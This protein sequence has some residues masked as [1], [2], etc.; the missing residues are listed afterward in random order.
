[1][2]KTTERPILGTRFDDGLHLAHE[3]HRTQVRKGKTTPYVAHLL[4]VCSLVLEDGGDE[5][6]AIGA[7]LHDAIEDAETVEEARRRA[8]TIRERFGERVLRI[9]LGLTD[10]DPE[11][12]ETL[13]YDDRK[14]RYI[15]RLWEAPLEVRRVCAAD[16][17]YNARAIVGDL[18]TIGDALWE[19]FNAGPEQIVSYD[20][21]VC[22]TLGATGTG[23]LADELERVVSEMVELSRR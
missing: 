23:R 3:W 4:G 8:E 22:K 1:M 17:L 13:S 18:R 6:E 20:L 10:G 5:D 14:A 19:R 7:L 9:V 15:A 12:K 2:H 16:K 11:E 21:T